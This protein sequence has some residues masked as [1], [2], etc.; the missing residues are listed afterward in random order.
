VEVE[1]TFLHFL[2]AVLITTLIH[3]AVALEV[4]ILEQQEQAAA[5]EVKVKVGLLLQLILLE[6][7]EGVAVAVAVE[8]TVMAHPMVDQDNFLFIPNKV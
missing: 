1:V 5:A 8:H 6:L 4:V 2:Q 7:L 3:Q